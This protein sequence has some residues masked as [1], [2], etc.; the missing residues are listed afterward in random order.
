MDAQA[1]APGST[2]TPTLPCA[3]LVDMSPRARCWQGSCPGG[4][5]AWPVPPDQPRPSRH[6][7]EPRSPGTVALAASLPGSSQ[8][9]G[10]ATKQ[11][12]PPDS[13]PTQPSG[14]RVPSRSW[15]HKSRDPVTA[16]P[17][18][19]SLRATQVRPWQPDTWPGP[20]LPRVSAPKHLQGVRGFRLTQK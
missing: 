4:E 1:A 10:A 20:T 9:L 19:H 5:G 14:P 2:V 3:G 7:Q 16:P 15:C 18:A 17:L 11:A 6:P 13:P 8:R 12:M